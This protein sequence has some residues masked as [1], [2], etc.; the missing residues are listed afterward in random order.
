MINDGITSAVYVA[1]NV[2]APDAPTRAFLVK[3]GN[4]VFPILHRLPDVEEKVSQTGR[5]VTAFSGR[6]IRAVVLISG[7]GQHDSENRTGR[8]A[9]CNIANQEGFQALLQPRG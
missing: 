2:P 9:M 4:N 1:F 5:L 6:E 3:D 7:N 8:G